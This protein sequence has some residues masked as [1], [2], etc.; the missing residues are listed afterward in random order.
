MI[1]IRFIKLKALKGA[2]L[3]FLTG[4]MFVKSEALKEARLI[5]LTGVTSIKSALPPFALETGAM[6]FLLNFF[7]RFS[8]RSEALKNSESNILTCFFLK[9]L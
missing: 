2:Q 3:I 6:T 8:G 5:F 7:A 4:I 1:R 9:K